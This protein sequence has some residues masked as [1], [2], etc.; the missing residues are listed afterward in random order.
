MCLT[1]KVQ[2]IIDARHGLHDAELDLDDP[3]RRLH[4]IVAMLHEDAREQRIAPLEIYKYILERRRQVARE[5]DTLAREVDPGLPERRIKAAT[6][7][8]LLYAAADTPD[9]QAA[10]RYLYRVAYF[11]MTRIL[12][13]RV[14]EDIGFIEQTLYDGGFEL[15]YERL[16][17]QIQ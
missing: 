13:A 14:W 4:R 8:P 12:L 15:W 9:G 16:R 7:K 2:A 10:N 11:A 5:I 1:Y 3:V 17:D 6:L